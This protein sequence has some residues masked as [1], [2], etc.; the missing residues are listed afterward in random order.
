MKQT[1]KGFV[2][3]PTTTLNALKNMLFSADNGV[4]LSNIINDLTPNADAKDLIAINIA[5]THKGVHV[6]IDERP[7]YAH[8]W[9]RDFVRYDYTGYSLIL[10][11]VKVHRT[12]C[13][14]QDDGTIQEL[15]TQNE[16]T[17]LSFD[18]WAEMT[19]DMTDIVKK[20]EE[21]TK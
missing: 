9:K 12:L 15:K 3:V 13:Q 10:G 11:V 5:L 20:I 19:T 6:N 7:H 16:T 21:R 1:K 8:E 18:M 14:L 17:C 2:E 4:D